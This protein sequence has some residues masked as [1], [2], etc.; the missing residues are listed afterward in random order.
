[1]TEAITIKG[2]PLAECTVNELHAEWEA[3]M[4]FDAAEGLSPEQSARLVAIE[5]E[6]ANRP[7]LDAI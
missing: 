6:M 3:G 1:M 5:R 2:K 4:Y 7:E